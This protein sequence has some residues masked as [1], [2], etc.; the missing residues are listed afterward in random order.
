MRI[1]QYLDP[2]QN[3][4][5]PKHLNHRQK[6][7][8]RPRLRLVLL[9]IVYQEQNRTN[10]TKMSQ[11]FYKCNIPFRIIEDST[12]RKMICSLRP[13]MTVPNRIDIGGSLLDQCY[14]EEIERNK[15]AIQSKWGTLHID[16]WKNCPDNSKYVEVVGQFV[17]LRAF[18]TTIT[19]EKQTSW[20]TLLYKAKNLRKECTTWLFML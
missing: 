7:N 15:E 16:G 2:L 5:F 20:Q 4:C 3:L 12:F 18:D 13:A 9:P 10:S 8:L 11:T 14:A 19:G 6:R 1:P 17:L